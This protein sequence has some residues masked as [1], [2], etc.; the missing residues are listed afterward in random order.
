MPIASCL[1]STLNFPIVNCPLP[2]V[3]FL[4]LAKPLRRKVCFLMIIHN[5]TLHNFFCTSF[6]YMSLLWSFL[7]KPILCYKYFSPPGFS[8]LT[9]CFLVKPV[10]RSDAEKT[11]R[12]QRCI[13]LMIIHNI[14]TI[15]YS[16][17]SFAYFMSNV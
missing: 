17:L 11:Q 14:C 1:L 9:S 7:Q 3:N 5:S 13:F 6:C 10:A 2:I 4:F 12:S 15:A 8:L 16:Q